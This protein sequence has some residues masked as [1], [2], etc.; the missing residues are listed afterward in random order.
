MKKPDKSKKKFQVRK[1]ILGNRRGKQIIGPKGRIRY[2]K[3]RA[4]DGTGTSHLRQ[5]EVELPSEEELE[6]EDLVD[7]TRLDPA[8]SDA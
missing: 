6:P 2:R 8:E 5:L 7:L 1:A 3:G 4:G